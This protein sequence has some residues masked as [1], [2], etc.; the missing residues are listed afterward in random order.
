MTMYYIEIIG[1]DMEKEIKNVSTILSRIVALEFENVVHTP[2][3]RAS[4]S[5]VFFETCK[6]VNVL[7]FTF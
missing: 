6:N 4:V 3:K 7:F 1:L 5:S 2:T